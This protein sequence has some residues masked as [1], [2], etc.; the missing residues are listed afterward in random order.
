MLAEKGKRIFLSSIRLASFVPPVV[1]IAAIGR[2]LFCDH[3][4]EAPA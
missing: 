2:D 3:S 1:Q 4:C